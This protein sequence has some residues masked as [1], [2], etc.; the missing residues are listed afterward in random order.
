M[1][2][3]EKI[4]RLRAVRV[5][6]AGSLIAWGAWGFAPYAM[7]DISTRATVNAPLIR[8]TAAADGTV[9][10]L[11]QPGH[12]FARQANLTLLN[13]SVD[14]GDTAQ[15]RTTAEIAQSTIDLTEQQLG[16]LG[17]QEGALKRRAGMFGGA[18]LQRLDSELVG[19][20]ATVSGCIAERAEND[21]AFE[22]ARKI[23][24]A[25]YLS[26]A[27][28]DKARAAAVSKRSECEVDASKLASLK[29][30]RD[31]AREGVYLGDSYNDAP[32][33]V[34]Q[35]DRL[36]LER[37][38]LQQALIEAKAKR[39]DAQK[40]LQD[41]DGRTRFVTPAGTL[42]WSM[43]SSPGAAIRAGERIMDLVD[44]RRRFIQV[45]LPA[46]RADAIGI[47]SSVNVRLIGATDWFTGKV[48]QISGGSIRKK[49]DLFAAT[50]ETLPGDRDVMVEVAL[51]TPSPDKFDPARRCDVGRLAEVRFGNLI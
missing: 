7:G 9:A 41:A 43:A 25:G 29:V 45:A 47:G 16:E 44:C 23:Y 18:T 39:A 31:A 6:F 14:T 32:Y 51:G 27:G 49:D 33:A 15:L 22:R 48:S 38:R 30:M 3:F 2:R 28:L 40:R 50:V 12:Y 8:L 17:H 13:L 10:P 21:A 5:G 37:Q 42:V 4:I 20:D 35:G 19:A 36:L 24:D 26:P 46:R 1:T 34:Q 11:P